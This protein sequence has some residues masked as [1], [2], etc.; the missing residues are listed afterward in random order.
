MLVASSPFGVLVPRWVIPSGLIGALV[1]WGCGLMAPL[2]GFA[3]SVC[4]TFGLTGLGVT[5][6]DCGTATGVMPVR[7]MVPPALGRLGSAL[8]GAYGDA[9]TSVTTPFRVIVPPE[10]I[11]GA[12]A[13]VGA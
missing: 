8:L 3:R 12:L 7:C 4:W 1:P 11:L 6:G 5:E 2:N 10:F 13:G 9:A